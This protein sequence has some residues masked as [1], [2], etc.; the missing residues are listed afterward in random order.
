MQVFW[1]LKFVMFLR[2]LLCLLLFYFAYTIL[3]GSDS[4]LYFLW[5]IFLVYWLKQLY[6]IVY[7]YSTILIVSDDFL[8]TQEWIF[9]VQ[10][11]EIPYKMINSIDVTNWIFIWNRITIYIG[12]DSPIIFKYISD[13]SY[14]KELIKQKISKNGE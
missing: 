3:Y 2:A 9:D 12:N 13:A 6:L 7:D 5:F 11:K 4:T 10:V 8:I 14:L 1:I